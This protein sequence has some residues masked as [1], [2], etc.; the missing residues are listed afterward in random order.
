MTAHDLEPAPTSAAPPAA[1]PADRRWWV[2]AVLGLAQLVVVLDAT[3]MN[4][5]LPTAQ[6][7]LGFT[8]AQRPWVLTAYTL[9]FGSL[10][11]LS[12]R[13]ADR[14][15][16]R[17]LFMTGL[18]GFA[19]ASAVG[20]ASTG[21]TMLVASRAVQGGFAA[22]LAPAALSLL[23][24]TFPDGPERAR[25]FGVF[26]AVGVSGSTL[27]LVLGGALTEYLSWRWTMYI[28]V[29]IA[30]PALIGALSIIAR[31]T[32]TAVRPRLD[33]AGTLTVCAGLFTLVYGFSNV[34]DHGWSAPSTLALLAAG[35]VLL[36]AFVAVETR[37]PAPLLPLRVLA[38]RNRAGGLLGM[39]VG[40]GALLGV[41]LFGAYYV[42]GTMHY[43][44]VKT[45]LAFLPQPFALL[46]T[47][48]VIGPRLNRRVS[49][50]VTVPVGMLLGAVGVALFTRVGVHG[51]YA[52]DV[53]P[54]LVVLGVGLGLIFATSTS[55]ATH[56]LARE[57]T[58]VGSALVSTSQQ[59]GGSIGVAVLNTIATTAGV[60]YFRHHTPGALTLARATVHGYT[61]A[62]W[63]A[64][65][66]FLLGA[67]ITAVLLRPGV[68]E[69][70]TASAPS[71]D[72]ET[73]PKAAAPAH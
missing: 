65:G 71:A 32:R 12:G 31:D 36:A 9:A 69:H 44:A 10:L 29:V 6:R 63:W 52:T 11:L 67:V 3:V 42:Q 27:G 50:K 48:A 38:D 53:L 72:D 13:L 19:A 61:T 16:R 64:S 73:T 33:L 55:I 25:A 2:L 15:G 34:A 60:H 35:V 24:L 37:V 58:G 8:D 56:G 7:D 21:F 66:F 5:A 54:T 57:D 70:L 46:V 62:F 45:G 43:S 40:I 28:N 4:I 14:L 18:I 23:T 30:I 41:I 26:G 1:S 17:R 47:A 22:L 49:P 20:G 51:D 68:P 59:I 39:F